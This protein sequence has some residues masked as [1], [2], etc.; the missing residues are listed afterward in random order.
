MLTAHEDAAWREPRAFCNGRQGRGVDYQIGQLG[1]P[2][3]RPGLSSRV[4]IAH[5]EISSES[6]AFFE[7]VT[8]AELRQVLNGIF[9]YRER[10][11]SGK[12]STVL[13]PQVGL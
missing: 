4:G 7:S 3:K 1:E 10:A 13:I 2:I 5:G 9:Q 6:Q 11:T 12:P 8:T